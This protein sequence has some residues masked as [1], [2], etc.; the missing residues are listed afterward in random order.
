MTS[1]QSVRHQKNQKHSEQKDDKTNENTSQISLPPTSVST[2]PTAREDK[3]DSVLKT[4]GRKSPVP[5]PIPEEKI[6]D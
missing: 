2:K 5:N 3:N 1:L 6:Q 4:T